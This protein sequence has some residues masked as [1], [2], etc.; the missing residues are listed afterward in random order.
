MIKQ[1][2][3]RATALAAVAVLSGCM[4]PATPATPRGD[5]PIARI[6][7]RGLTDPA[8]GKNQV[9]V[10]RDP[11]MWGGG[12][13]LTFSVNYVVLADL[14]P[15]E[16]ISAWLPDGTYTFSVAPNPNPQNL[17]ASRNVNVTLQGGQ[18]RLVRIGGN[19]Y[20]TSIEPDGAANPLP[21]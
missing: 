12:N 16:S 3:T 1:L 14:Q 4:T 21:K 11:A 2:F 13:L 15:G 19:I 10:T 18:H 5:V 7:N 9:T 6:F 8:A 17:T 20:G